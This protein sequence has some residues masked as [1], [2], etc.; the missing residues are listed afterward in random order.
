LA[1]IASPLRAI[2]VVEVFSVSAISAVIPAL[3]GIRA[4]TLFDGRRPRSIAPHDEG[5][6]P[7]L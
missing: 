6:I 2:P 4:L 1:R 7:P 5:F 3:A